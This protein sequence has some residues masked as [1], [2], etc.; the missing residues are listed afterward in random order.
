[1]TALTPQKHPI[2]YI[3]LS[4]I[5]ISAL[6]TAA[7]R[8]SEENSNNTQD[9]HRL[10]SVVSIISSCLILASLPLML[11]MA[12][13][14][15]LLKKFIP[16]LQ[17]AMPDTTRIQQ[18]EQV[19]R[20]N[21]IL[22][23]NERY[24]EKFKYLPDE[25]ISEARANVTA[26]LRPEQQEGAVIQ[27]SS[28]AFQKYEGLIGG[29]IP[30][31]LH[32]TKAPYTQES[33]KNGIEKHRAELANGRSGPNQIA[34][35]I[36][37]ANINLDSLI[38]LSQQ[39][40][41]LPEI[42]YDLS[43]LLVMND[44][45]EQYSHQLTALINNPQP[46][47]ITKFASLYFHVVYENLLHDALQ[48]TIKLGFAAAFWQCSFMLGQYWLNYQE[49]NN[50]E[51]TWDKVA[52][53]LLTGIGA[54]IGLVFGISLAQLLLYSTRGGIHPKNYI[55]LCLQLTLSCTVADLLWQ[56]LTDIADIYFT[57]V[58]STSPVLAYI[59]G[60][61][62]Y[63]LVYFSEGFIFK[64][65]HN[66]LNQLH[67]R[68]NQVLFDCD[69]RFVALLSV[70]YCSFKLIPTL[71]A[72]ATGISPTTFNPSSI[73][74]AC[75]SAGVGTALL[76][77]LFLLG[78]IIKKTNTL[79]DHINQLCERKDAAPE[80]IESKSK[81]SLSVSLLEDTYQLNEFTSSDNEKHHM[82]SP[83]LE[84]NCGL[85]SIIAYP[86]TYFAPAATTIANTIEACTPGF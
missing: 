47:D 16:I 34:Y 48:T 5:T 59:T 14:N 46:V 52:I 15:Y 6:L 77:F 51:L 24:S 81:S 29:W 27:I 36:D 57:T 44:P 39:D 3:P 78:E 61:P 79:T 76:P 72:L 66:S 9:N 65:V 22:R 32:S 49:Y 26:F 75:L 84:K 70:A 20:K 54:S 21:T 7:L 10:S 31:F 23:F 58:C 73:L 69:N 63:L 2:T 1:M 85:T 56:P 38:A 60:L 86:F 35:D 37:S 8:I 12:R 42:A 41:N 74:I 82:N 18:I 17:L 25:L 13:D 33:L 71:F 50:T 19:L 28:E 40:N 45:E 67:S 80:D 64:A 43:Q 55:T 68:G 4:L 83:L 30:L 11:Y 62:V 53:W